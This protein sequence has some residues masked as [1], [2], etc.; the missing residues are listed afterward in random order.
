MEEAVRMDAVTIEVKG[1][2]RPVWIYVNE[3]G[4]YVCIL[5][6]SFPP[7]LW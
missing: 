3:L 7:C 1:D 6:T 5:H 2:P 4:I